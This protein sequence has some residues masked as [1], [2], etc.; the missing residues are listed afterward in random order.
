MGHPR[1][2]LFCSI[3]EGIRDQLGVLLCA[4]LVLG[5]QLSFGSQFFFIWVAFKARQGFRNLFFYVWTTEWLG[6]CQR[7][8]RHGIVPAPDP[9]ARRISAARDETSWRHFGSIEL[10]TMILPPL[11][12]TNIPFKATG[13]MVAYLH[14]PVRPERDVGRRRR[15]HP[16]LFLPGVLARESRISLHSV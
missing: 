10:T 13:Y 6:L 2:A 12:W 9:T 16:A 7:C 11:D 15:F 14:G 8:Q 5:I 1:T 4:D 3:I